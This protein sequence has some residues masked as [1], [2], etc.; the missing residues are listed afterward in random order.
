MIYKNQMPYIAI[1]SLIGMGINAF[2]FSIAKNRKYIQK[3][4]ELENE[5][6][7]LNEQMVKIK[8]ERSKTITIPN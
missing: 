6:I 8:L 3:I 5:N 2:Q 4:S 7:K 1:G